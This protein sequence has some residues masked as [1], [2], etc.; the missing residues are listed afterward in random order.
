MTFSTDRA[1]NNNG[2]AGILRSCPWLISVCDSRG[3]RSRAQCDF[4]QRFSAAMRAI[5][6]L[7]SAVSFSALAFPPLRP[8]PF[9]SADVPPCFHERPEPDFFDVAISGRCPAAG[10]AQTA[11]PATAGVT[12]PDER[13]RP[14]QPVEPAGL[15][16]T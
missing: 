6:A 9:F 5:S 2:H 8:A 1:A 13:L 10:R 7:R 4:F 12:G 11:G 15:V 3:N 16:V 14:A